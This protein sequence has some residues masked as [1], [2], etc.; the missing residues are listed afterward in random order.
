[1]DC[2]IITGLAGAGKSRVAD[3][4]EDLD[5]YCVDNIPSAFARTASIMLCNA[6]LPF[7]LKIADMGAEQALKADKHLRKGLTA[8]N[9][10]LTLA[11]TAKKQ[12]RVL[13]DADEL[14][15]GF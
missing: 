4:L 10:L 8:Y 2:L 9:G 12:N 15:K 3:M 6:T 14:V 13:T 1:M 7:L 5:Y 11:E